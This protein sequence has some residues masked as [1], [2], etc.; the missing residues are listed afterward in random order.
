VFCAIAPLPAIRDLPEA[1]SHD[2]DVNDHIGCPDHREVLVRRDPQIGVAVE[3]KGIQRAPNS[4]RD[5]ATPATW[6]RRGSA[7]VQAH[8]DALM[9]P[10]AAPPNV[11]CELPAGPTD[12]QCV[13]RPP[14]RVR[15][16]RQGPRQAAQPHRSSRASPRSIHCKPLPQFSRES[17]AERPRQSA[18]PA[19]LMIRQ[20]SRAS[21]FAPC[22]MFHIWKKE[23]ETVCGTVSL[24]NDIAISDWRE[25]C[26]LPRRCRDHRQPD[27]DRLSPGNVA[28][29]CAEQRG[30]KDA[31][32]VHPITFIFLRRIN[33]ID[34]IRR[35]EDDFPLPRSFTSGARFLLHPLSL[36]ALSLRMS[37]SWRVL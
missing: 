16:R 13:R 17:S 3:R 33:G 29:N 18:Q 20:P 37:L 14:R 9:R 11:G 10:M 23:I 26:A 35:Y 21:P 32:P 30:I 1:D 25:V 6:G 31:S 2:S 8:P 7:S 12:L 27:R 24:K 34:F 19:D 36:R 5:R 4:P 15:R 22:L 28:A